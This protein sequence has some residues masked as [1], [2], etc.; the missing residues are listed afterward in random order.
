MADLSLSLVSHTNVGKTTL[1]RTLLGRDIGEVRDAAHVTETVEP[2]PMVESPAGDRL[3][4]WDTPGFGDSLR[5]ARR[6][7][8]AGS[9]LGWLLSE[10]WDRWRDRAFWASQRAI[11][12]VLE[13][14]DVALYLVNAAEAPEDAGYLAPELQVLGLLGKPVIVL[15]NQ[16]GEPGAPGDEAAQLQRWRS[17]L[18]ALASQ[19]AAAG[20][21]PARLHAVL[22][23]DAFTRCWLQEAVLLQAVAEA[24]PAQS[25][26][27]MDRLAA[28]WRA[29][30]QATFGAAMQALAGRIT[31]AAL[32]RERV[33]DGG[34]RAPLRQVGQRLG[35]LF[36]R[37][38]DDGDNPQAQAMAALADRLDADIR[39]S[40]ETL[41]RLHRLQGDAAGEVLDRL[42]RHFAR[43]EPVNEGRAALWG[44]LVTGA[45]AGLKADLA[46]GGLT[47]G[48]GLLAGGVL[49]A[50]GAAG[51]ARGVNRVRGLDQPLLAW[52]EPVLDA[53]LRSALLGYLAVAHHGRGRGEWRQ[54]DAPPAWEAAVD[55]SLAE[56]DEAR[57]SLWQRR[58]R[59]LATPPRRQGLADDEAGPVGRGRPAEVEAPEDF[60]A[61]MAT[62][63]DSLGGAVLQRLYPEA[64]ALAGLSISPRP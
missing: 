60:S 27:A 25:R 58:A 20:L 52:D 61:D 4:L 34:W 18:D 11:R 12:H 42:A 38:T 9:P 5:L 56:H 10:V 59:L 1:A 28:A 47:M 31:R 30:Q 44:G 26:A 32:D 46:S 63:M 54:G 48:G 40:T 35:Q 19:A 15:L 39:R 62:L 53:L 3:L 45:L 6:L 23:L 17:H 16:L 24:L 2:H 57:S 37:S 13:Q 41:I 21:A 55:E 50:L 22:P 7:A 14:A 29:R 33:P 64:A 49:G 51:A 43:R 8:Q 36:G